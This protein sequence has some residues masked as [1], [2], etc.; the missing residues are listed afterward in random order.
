MARTPTKNM[1]GGHAM[2]VKDIILQCY[3]C[4]SEFTF[5]ASEQ[6]Q[7]LS[8]GYTNSPKRCLTCL[9]QRKARQAGKVQ[10]NFI[11]AIGNSAGNR[12]EMFSAV[13]VECK[14]ETRVPFKPSP[15]K[16]VYCGTCYY[17]NKDNR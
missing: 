11:N 17:K 2:T 9:E 13:C 1:R 14:K 8:M 16:P 12:K 4:G 10:N 3:N 6:Q 5:S 15:S 7:F